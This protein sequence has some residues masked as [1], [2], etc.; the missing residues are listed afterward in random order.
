MVPRDMDGDDDQ[1]N[2]W[3]VGDVLRAAIGFSSSW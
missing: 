1:V 3:V 2:T